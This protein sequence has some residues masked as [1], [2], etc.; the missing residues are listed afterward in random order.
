V[1]GAA[2][3]RKFLLSR[4]EVFIQTMTEK[5]MGYSLGRSVDY[6]DM[7]TIRRILRDAKANDYRF[8][9]IV[10]GIVSSPAFQM[11][12]KPTP[13]VENASSAEPARLAPVAASIR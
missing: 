2:G 9:S 6:Y 8:S 7:P 4:R 11:R 3:L 5:L 12:I 13:V 1:D 10:Q